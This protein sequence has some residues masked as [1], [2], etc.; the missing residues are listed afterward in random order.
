MKKPLSIALAASIAISAIGL[1]AAPAAA[2][3][4]HND[5]AAIAIFGAI[6]GMA[7]IAAASQHHHRDRGYYYGDYPP[8]PPPP[9]YYGGYRD[10]DPHVAWCLGHYRTYDPATNTY[11]RRPGVPAVCYSPY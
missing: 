10:Y 5:A 6:A 9:R 7:V 4:R 11:F 3:S 8:P 1:S 2:R